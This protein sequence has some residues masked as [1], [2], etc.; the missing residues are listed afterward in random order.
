MF[1]MIAKI[2]LA[3]I[4]LTSPAWADG[5]M[6]KAEVVKVDK[7]AGKVTLKHGPI[8]NLDMD[9]MTMVFRVADPAMLDKL[10]VGQQIEFEADRVNGA[11]TVVKVGKGH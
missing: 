9:A 10:K 2:A 7:P 4:L 3:A 8:K 6:V 1:R 5:N 11:I